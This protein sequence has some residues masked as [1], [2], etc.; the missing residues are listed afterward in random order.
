[1]ARKVHEFEQQTYYYTYGPHPPWLELLPAT[2]FAR[3]P[4]TPWDGTTPAIRCLP[5]NSSEI[6][7]PS[8]CP[9]IRRSDL[10]SSKEQDPATCSP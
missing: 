8:S 3:K 4:L 2:L 9:I 1:M 7:R 10:Y 6:A 5:K